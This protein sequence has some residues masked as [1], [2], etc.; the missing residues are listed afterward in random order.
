MSRRRALPGSNDQARGA[1]SGLPPLEIV[2]M[3]AVLPARETATLWEPGM[4][5]GP[6]GCLELQEC[7]GSG[8]ACVVHALFDHVSGTR[9]AAKF[10]LPGVHDTGPAAL[11]AEAKLTAALRHPNI[12]RVQ[13]W[14]E[15]SDVAYLLMEYVDGTTLKQVL[16]TRQLTN[17]EAL[18]VV[19][20][21][22]SAL[23]Y[24]HQHGIFHLDLKP[25]NVLVSREG[26]VK[27]IDFGVGTSLVAG[28]LT[29][30]N[31]VVGTP[32][33][34]APEQW[35]TGDVDVRADIWAIG[36]LLY[37]MY[38]TRGGFS[39]RALRAPVQWAND[40]VLRERS[41]VPSVLTRILEQTLNID[42]NGRFQSASALRTALLHASPALLESVG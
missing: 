26:E 27:L 5:F 25:S 3:P 8:G 16:A 13:D 10:Q 18:R 42:P 14:D 19:L 32:F 31:A 23:E 21:V 33:Y 15:S 24:A 9:M 35:T 39:H 2:S 17:A 36:S 20:D 37:E 30:A 22:V 4:R 28:L 34:M 7:L 38:C 11:R 1:I 40:H 41:P 29:E 12:I 6:G